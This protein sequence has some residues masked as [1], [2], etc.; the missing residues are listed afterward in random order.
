[1]LPAINPEHLANVKVK[2]RERV[3]DTHSG[4]AEVVREA[5]IL[6]AMLEATRGIT[7]ALTVDVVITHVHSAQSHKCHAVTVELH[8]CPS[9]AP[10]GQA[11]L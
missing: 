2:A 7:L 1:M 10:E 6:T 5:A 8:I 9:S 11:D 3:D 4:L